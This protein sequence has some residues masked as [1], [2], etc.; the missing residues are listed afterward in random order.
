LQ[1]GLF[2]ITLL[3][4]C[5]VG[6]TFCLVGQRLLP[7]ASCGRCTV[8]KFSAVG[9]PVVGYCCCCFPLPT[10]VL[11]ASMKITTFLRRGSALPPLSLSLFLSLSLC[12][13]CCSCA[14]SLMQEYLLPGSQAAAGHAVLKR[15]GQYSQFS[16]RASIASERTAFRSH[17]AS[18]S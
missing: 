10:E 11:A 13:C 12:V 15:A 14:M 3:G 5:L 16:C 18:H 4:R 9:R 7:E 6:C 2:A 1:S 17:I 8:T